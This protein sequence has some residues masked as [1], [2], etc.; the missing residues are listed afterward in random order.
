MWIAIAAL[1][2]TV[3]AIF[4]A[5]V[6][7]AHATSRE[8]EREGELFSVVAKGTLPLTCFFRDG[9]PGDPL[10]LRLTATEAQLGAAFTEAGWY[11]ADEITL[12]TSI[13]I[14]ADSLLAREYSTAPMSNLYLYGRRQDYGF[15]KPG[16]SVRERDHVRFWDSSLREADGRSLWLGAATKDIDV[17]LSPRT[18]LPTHRIAPNVDDERDLVVEDL[19]RAGWVLEQDYIQALDD[20]SVHTNAYGDT[21]TSDGRVA[22]LVLADV[23]VLLPFADD[24]RGPTLGL[25]RLLSRVLRG[26]LPRRAVE[27]ARRLRE[28]R[29]RREQEQQ[30]IEHAEEPVP[31]GRADEA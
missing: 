6:S 4:I 22:A 19:V 3:V 5:R 13:R 24:V 23:P 12:V 10:N 11:R 9:S 15:Q 16:R 7:R 1:V 21:Y 28:R 17:K 29:K 27:R 30:E 18:H 8:A 20:S 31:T 14:A 25:A 2:L 26:R